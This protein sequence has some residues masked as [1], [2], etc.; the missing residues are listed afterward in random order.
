M[1][2]MNFI[3]RKID[4]EYHV[5]YYAH[6]KYWKGIRLCVDVWDAV[7]WCKRYNLR[8]AEIGA[9]PMMMNYI[10][11]KEVDVQCSLNCPECESGKDCNP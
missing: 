8:V 7:T 9:K 4:N 5:G 6:N 2:G 10:E 3:V 1:V 11:D